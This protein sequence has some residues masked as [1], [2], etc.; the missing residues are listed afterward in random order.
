MFPL[1][2]LLLAGPVS[3]PGMSSSVDP[4]FLSLA[5]E[6]EA[7]LR[8]GNPAALDARLDGDELLQRVTRGLPVS[9]AFIEELTADVHKRGWPLGR[10]LL[11]SGGQGL[12]VRLLHVRMRGRTPFALFRVLSD[13][14]LNYLEFELGRNARNEAV[15]F[16]LHP[17]LEGERLSESSWR[18]YLLAAAERGQCLTQRL[19][20]PDREWVEHLPQL[21]RIERLL[22]EDRDREALEEMDRLPPRVR[23][24]R[25]TQ[26]RRLAVL[27]SLDEAEY[28]LGL[29]TFEKAFP[30]DPLLD[31]FALDNPLLRGEGAV[32]MQ[33][34]D[35]LD[36]RVGDPYLHYLR[37]MVMLRQEDLAGAKRSF[38]KALEGD[39]ALLAP[40]VELLSLAIEEADHAGAVR[41]LEAM[42][43]EI[44]GG[45]MRVRIEDG[46]HASAFLESAEYK[47]WLGRQVAR[48]RRDGGS[49]LSGPTVP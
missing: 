42:E 25:F 7:A 33:A 32:M 21:R 19:R 12:Q 13:S 24:A 8:D 47:A 40:Y 43:R 36:R 1:L 20:G 22:A 2:W 3:P 10:R 11:G 4:A 6:V 45:E 29:L 16:D 23:E 18:V 5:R 39:P 27:A 28:A 44:K 14:G 49:E 37:G 35:R 26:L 15:I 46:P 31:L 34:I 9:S 41:L 30:G 48:E 17:Y 38:Q